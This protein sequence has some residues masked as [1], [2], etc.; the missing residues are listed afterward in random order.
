MRWS[1]VVMQALMLSLF[2]FVALTYLRVERKML[3]AMYMPQI[4]QD[5]VNKFGI[6][7]RTTDV[8]F[9]DGASNIQKAGQIL[10]QIFPRAHWFHGGKHVL[11]LFSVNSQS[12]RQSRFQYCIF[13][14]WQCCKADKSSSP[15]NV[16]GSGANHGIHLQLMTHAL[17]VNNG[18]KVGLLRGAEIWFATWFYTPHSLLCQ[19]KDM[20]ETVHS[21]YFATLAYNDEN[22]LSVQD[23]EISQFWSTIYCLLRAIFP[24]LSEL[25]DCDTNKLVMDMNYYF[26][27]RAGN[28]L[29]R[30]SSLMSDH[31]VFCFKRRNF[32][33]E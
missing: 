4:F 8:Y 6:D 20:L 7:D 27:D 11:S 23:I 2:A 24:A 3:N 31:L 25:R 18:K 13:C 22:D 19:K 10:C 9:F 16:F 30:S 5:K 28:A 17:A 14:V 1:C 26:C 29:L 15:F 12:W 32:L 33:R 21:I